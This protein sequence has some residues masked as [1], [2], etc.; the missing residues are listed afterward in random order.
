MKTKRLLAVLLCVACAAASTRAQVVLPERGGERGV[1]ENVFGLGLA[2][3]A[4]TG[5]GLSFRH[6]LPGSWSYEIT[7]GVIKVDDKTS[8]A[9]GGEIE[10]DLVRA[11]A[12]RFF[13][14]GGMGYYY[15]GRGGRN[16]IDGP[17]RVGLGIGGEL[18]VSAGFHV[19]G[20]L[21]FTYFS[22]ATILPLPQVGIYYYFY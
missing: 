9:I 12:S 4:A 3:G 7:G 2:V 5:I 6:H 15:G 1:R 19:S 8:Y 16:T 13:V 11:T 14:A 18:P 20:E 21:L 22:D 17:V 10:Y